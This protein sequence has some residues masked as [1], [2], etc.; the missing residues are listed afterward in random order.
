[1]F[2]SSEC[3]INIVCAYFLEGMCFLVRVKEVRPTLADLPKV[4][5]IVGGKELD[6]ESRQCSISVSL[7]RVL[8]FAVR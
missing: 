7:A 4:Q 1:M 8:Q 3:T 6:V 5:H 2:G